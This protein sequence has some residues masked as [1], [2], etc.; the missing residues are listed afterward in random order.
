MRNKRIGITAS[1]ICIVLGAVLM[2][3]GWLMGGHAG[4]YIDQSGVHGADDMNT[5]EPIQDHM[6]LDEFDSIDIQ[7]DYADVKL[8]LSDEF[9]VEYRL[10][11]NPGKPVCEVRNGRF[12]FQETRRSLPFNI[13]FFTGSFGIESD[14]PHYFVTVKIPKNTKLSEAVFDIESGDLDISSLQ[15][16]ILKINDEY[17]KI[18]I[19]EATG[20]RLAIK[21]DSCDLKADRLDFSETEISNDYGNI[22]MKDASGERLTVKLES[23]DCMIER[24]DFSEAKITDSYGD[25]RL[26]LPGEAENYGLNLKTEYGDIR[27][28]NENIEDEYEENEVIY[29]TTG[30]NKKKVSVFCEDGNIEIQSAR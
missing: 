23:C 20:E 22:K 27:V 14:D 12:I 19:S 13:G 2:M 4:F 7:V 6:T 5:P 28:G 10:I 25:I 18:E 21:L 30:D 17:G 29:T 16:D 11:G 3:A 15:A 9:S 1:I 26:G 8:L 24:M